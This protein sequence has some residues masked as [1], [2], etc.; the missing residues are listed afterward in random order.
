[1]EN[2]FDFGT[3]AITFKPALTRRR[4]PIRGW[5]LIKLGLILAFASGLFAILASAVMA[6]CE[7]ARRSQCTCNLCQ[8]KLALH[9]YHETYG[10]LPP[11]Y[12]VDANGKPMHS[13]RMLIMPFLEQSGIF[14]QYDFSEPWNGPN[15]IKLLDSMPSNLACP[16]R[17]DKPIKLTSYVV[18]TDRER[19][20]PG[21][22]RSS[23]RTSPTG[24]QIH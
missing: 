14:N 16:S 11:A 10:T 4:S 6:A 15:N 21:P 9:N 19:C 22:L 1:M 3:S 2:D 13:W 18:I 24:W 17:L 5:T 7:A 8:I 12:I 20:S 23:S